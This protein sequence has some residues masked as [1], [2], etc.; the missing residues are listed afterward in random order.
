MSSAFHAET[1]GQTDRVKRTL[2]DMLRH[3]VGPSQDDWDLRLPC[4]EF[5]LKNAVKA[6]TVHTP[7]YLNHGRH[8]RSPAGL[9]MDTAHRAAIEVVENL[10]EAMSRAKDCLSIYYHLLKHERKHSC[11]SAGG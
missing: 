1:D 9:T 11:S 8:P 4:A 10:N 2:E 7:F 6:A 5:A 3:Y